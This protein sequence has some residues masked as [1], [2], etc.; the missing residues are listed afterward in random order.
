MASS[1]GSTTHRP[2]APSRSATITANGFALTI[3]G[4]NNRYINDD[5]VAQAIAQFYSRAGIEAKVETMPSS[6]YF[7]RAT[8][9]DFGYM[10][11]GWGTES[12]EQGTRGKRVTADGRQAA[13]RGERRGMGT[14]QRVLSIVVMTWVSMADG[15][16]GPRPLRPS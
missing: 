4:P 5:K 7:T 16:A 9:G 15:S 3:H 14:S 12:N 2:R 11:L 10:L 8:K 1:A 13:S 6:V